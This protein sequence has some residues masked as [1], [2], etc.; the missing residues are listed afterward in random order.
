MNIRTYVYIN[1]YDCT[2]V[3]MYVLLT[4]NWRKWMAS[5][6]LIRLHARA[7]GEG[8]T[9]RQIRQMTHCDRKRERH[10]PFGIGANGW[11]G[12]TA[13]SEPRFVRVL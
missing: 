6:K 11:R 1:T 8:A 13:H 4:D 2:I 3:H 10:K 12:I 7:V 9:R 5:V